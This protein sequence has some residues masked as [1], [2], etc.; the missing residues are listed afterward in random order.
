MGISS[1]TSLHHQDIALLQPAQSTIALVL[2]LPNSSGRGIEITEAEVLRERVKQLQEMYEDRLKSL[3]DQIN[4]T[5]LLIDQ[6]EIIRTMREDTAS[7][8]YVTERVKVVVCY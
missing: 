5:I 6:D 3:Q 7:R 1:L 8:E 2:Q 4:N